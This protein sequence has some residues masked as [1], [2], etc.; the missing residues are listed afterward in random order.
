[1]GKNPR[2]KENNN[3]NNNNKRSLYLVLSQTLSIALEDTLRRSVSCVCNSDHET[4][5]R[6]S[7]N[8]GTQPL[9]DG[10]CFSCGDSALSITASILGILT[11]FYAVLVGVRFYYVSLLDAEEQMRATMKSLETSFREARDIS[12]TLESMTPEHSTSEPRP[13]DDSVKELVYNAGR[14]LSDL[15]AMTRKFMDSGR[16]GSLGR[17]WRR[18]VRFVIIQE[19]LQKKIAEKDQMMGDLRQMRLK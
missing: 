5:P 17:I 14:Q 9:P 19:E 12:I 4:K 16:Y 6:D 2:G 7:V 18:R 13:E 8:M 3:N 11:F 15:A 10:S 1:M